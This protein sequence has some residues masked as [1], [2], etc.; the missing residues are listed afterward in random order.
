MPTIT[1]RQLAF[2]SLLKIE[3]DDR[4]AN[5]EVAVSLGRADLSGE[6]SALYTRLVY[7]VTERRIT[8]DEILSQYVARKADTVDEEARTALRMG[9]YQL[10]YMDR[11]PEYAAVGESVSLVSG[12]ARGFVN[13]VLRSFLRKGKSYRLPSGPPARRLSAAYS[14]PEDLAALL[15]SQY[16]EEK[17]ERILSSFLSEDR[18]MSLRVN[19]LK[20]T[21]EEVLRVMEAEGLEGRVSPVTPDVLLV[22]S[23]GNWMGRHPGLGFV[24]DASSR[25]AVRAAGLKPGMTVVDV[26]AAPGG[27][28]F[29]AA[30]DLEND[31]TVYAFDLHGNKLSP[32]V[33]GCETLGITIVKTEQRDARHVR[34][35][36]IAQADAVLCD[37]PCSGIGVIGKKPEIRYRASETARRLP[38]V[39][40]EILEGAA[41]Y[42][43]KGGTLVYSTC[44]LNRRENEEVVSDFLARHGDFSPAELP[45]DF[46]KGIRSGEFLTLTPDEDGSDGFFIAKMIRKD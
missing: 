33:K 30:M 41:A 1:A 31:G 24:Q 15:L 38:E 39:Q 6:D 25:L 46:P 8:L 37:A 29:S 11:I 45:E 9:L 35:D 36:L 18:P 16:G 42:V 10:L 21:P 14:V 7:G 4:Y 13:G 19:T 32:V 43:K 26:C 40:S 12:R 5:L 2:R 23:P 3:R 17:T 34:E 28:T 22:S 44:T 20:T 27:K